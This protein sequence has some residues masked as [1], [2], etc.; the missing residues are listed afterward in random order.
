MVS[1]IAALGGAFLL[2]EKLKPH[3]PALE[4]ALRA[5]NASGDPYNFVN[6]EIFN[7]GGQGDSCFDFSH[8]D[9]S[10]FDARAFDSFDAGFSDAAGGDGGGGD[11][12]SSGC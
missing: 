4:K 7:S 3:Y 6:S 12:V 11:S 2:V 8:L 1:L 9:F 10:C 5:L